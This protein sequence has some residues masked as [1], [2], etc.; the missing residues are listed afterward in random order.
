MQ[1]IALLRQEVAELKQENADRKKVE[2]QVQHLNLVLRAIRNVNQVIAR[3]TDRSQL[4]KG[5]CRSLTETRGCHNAWIALLDESDKLREYAESGLGD[6]FLP[7]KERLER[8]EL[9]YCARRALEQSSPVVTE[10][11]PL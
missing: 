8:G 11:P 5:I 10:N 7:M 3:E 2:E 4:L 9:T 1:E 6:D